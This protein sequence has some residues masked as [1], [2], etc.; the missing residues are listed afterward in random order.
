MDGFVLRPQGVETSMGWEKFTNQKLTDGAASPAALTV[1]K[2]DQYFQR[3]GN[4]YAVAITNRRAYFFNEADDLW[5][6]ITPGTK[7][8]TTV[9]ADSLLGQKVLNVAS[10]TGYAVGDTIIINE[11]GARQETGVVDSISVGASLT[12]LANMT[13]THTAVQADAVKRTYAAAIVDVDSAA[14]A[15]TTET[16]TDFSLCTSPVQ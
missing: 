15:T 7:A 4:N 12:L 11:G 6:P 10:T 8:Y 14:A 3:S 1:L 9:D 2:L 13:F 16:V 5:I